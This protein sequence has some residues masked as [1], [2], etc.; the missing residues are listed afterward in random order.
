M[1]YI[2]NNTN[3][4]RPKKFSRKFIMVSQDSNSINGRGGRDLRTI[5][6]E[7]YLLSWEIVSPSELSSIL[8]IVEV[9]EPVKFSVTEGDLTISEISVIVRV[10]QIEY[11][12]PGDSYYAMFSIE[13]EEVQ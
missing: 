2:L 10:G 8:S 1:S 11:V 7:S 13:L 4:P 9:N 12:I 5:T 6:K 3:L